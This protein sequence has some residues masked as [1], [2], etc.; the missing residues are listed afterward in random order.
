[1]EYSDEYLSR[2]AEENKIAFCFVWQCTD[3][4]YASGLPILMDTYEVFGSKCGFCFTLPWIEYYR[5]LYQKIFTPAYAPWIEPLLYHT[6][7]SNFYQRGAIQRP[8]FVPEHCFQPPRLS[9]ETFKTHVA[10]ALSAVRDM[11]GEGWLPRGNCLPI[12]DMEMLSHEHRAIQEVGFK[13]GMAHAGTGIDE[14]PEP[15]ALLAAD[16]DCPVLRFT[17]FGAFPGMPKSKGFAASGNDTL[18][19]HIRK[20]EWLERNLDG[21]ATITTT[22]DTGGGWMVSQ[23]NMHAGKRAATDILP[24]CDYSPM[25]RSYL[26]NYVTKGGVSGRVFPCKPSEAIRY[27]KIVRRRDKKATG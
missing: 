16:S 9:V 8:E 19:G 20:L 14:V 13:Y 5:D 4:A 25:Y 17:K 2:C 23:L 11:L 22:T 3:I 26:Q 1:M 7:L 15:N 21:P 10:F 24:N 6:G 27:E 18:P 12:W